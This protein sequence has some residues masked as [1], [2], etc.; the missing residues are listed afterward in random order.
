MADGIDIDTRELEALA[1]SLGQVPAAVIGAARGVVKMGALNIKNDTR[2]N[3]SK[4]PSWKR[5]AASVNYTMTGNAFYSEATVGYDDVGQGELA[6]IYEFGSATRAPHPTLY[7][8][9][10]RELPRFEKALGDVAG[11]VTEDLL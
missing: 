11:K 10:A 6:G 7:P 5:L 2:K 8:A 4:D 9:A 1:A 3:V